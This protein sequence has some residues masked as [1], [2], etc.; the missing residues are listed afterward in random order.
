MNA[1][2]ETRIDF[3]KDE[4]VAVLAVVNLAVRELTDQ[5]AGGEDLSSLLST[6][7]KLCRHLAISLE[8]ICE[9]S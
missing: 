3:T 5:D 4:A 7:R 8:E 2:E 9:P 6:R 1:T